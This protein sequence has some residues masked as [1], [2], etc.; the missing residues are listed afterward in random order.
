MDRKILVGSII[1]VA[2]LV[3][4]SFTSV[5]GY[6]SV[7]SNMSNSPLFNIRTSRAIGEE[8]KILTS[9]YFGRGYTLPF[10]KRDDKAVMF[11]KVVD[12]IRKMDDETFQKFIATFINHAQMDERFNGINPYEIKETVNLIRIND[13]SIP[14]LDADTKQLASYGPGLPCPITSGSSPRDVLLCLVGF[15]LLPFVLIGMFIIWCFSDEGGPRTG[16]FCP[17]AM[18][19]PCENTLRKLK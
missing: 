10:P 3:L 5:V 8:S 7:E 12:A 15:L 18:N 1:A 6:Q 11:Q 4:V 16:V 14:I 2:I 9:N 17:T 13:K 19:P